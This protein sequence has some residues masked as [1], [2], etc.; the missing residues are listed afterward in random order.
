MPAGYSHPRDDPA[1]PPRAVTPDELPSAPAGKGVS[2]TVRPKAADCDLDGEQ[3][4][5]EESYDQPVARPASRTSGVYT[6]VVCVCVCVCAHRCCM[7]ACLAC[8]LQYVRHDIVLLVPELRWAALAFISCPA[9][10]QSTCGALRTRGC[11]AFGTQHCGTRFL[12]P[13]LSLSVFLSVCLSV[14]D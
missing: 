12:P 3:D 5:A 14:L 2:T 4:Y 1:S 7:C 13:P 10:R 8:V 11:V 9:S 6:D